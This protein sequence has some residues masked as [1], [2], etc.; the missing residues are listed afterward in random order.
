[1]G[2][3]GGDTPA[4]QLGDRGGH[5]DLLGVDL[6]RHVVF[7]V[8]DA[9]AS[10][11]GGRGLGGVA[12]SLGGVHRGHGGKGEVAR[13]G[14]IGRG[15]LELHPRRVL[16]RDSRVREDLSAPRSLC[17]GNLREHRVA[18][19]FCLFPLLLE[20]LALLFSLLLLLLELLALLL[21]LLLLLLSLFLLV[22]SLL[23]LLLSL[24]LLLLLSLF[25][26]LRIPLGVFSLPV[27]LL[28]VLLPGV[29]AVRKAGRP[30]RRRGR[31]HTPFVVVGVPIGLLA[32][33][34]VARAPEIVLQLHRPAHRYPCAVTALARPG[35][36]Q[37]PAVLQRAGSLVAVAPEQERRL[38]PRVVVVDL[39][40]LRDAPRIIRGHCSGVPAARVEVRGCRPRGFVPAVE[41]PA[42][43]HDAHDAGM[44]GVVRFVEAHGV[45]VV[46]V[47]DG[48]APALVHEEFGSNGAA[49]AR[50]EERLLASLDVHAAW[51][52]TRVGGSVLAR[53]RGPGVGR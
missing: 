43:E 52:V 11:R 9:A 24:L 46:V 49:G 10:A 17:V 26:L 37:P 4:L 14:G 48:V 36:V 21:S 41:G 13:G 20:L 22:L 25:L 7:G 2:G 19:G 29:V 8:E 35:L 32:V 15:L 47:G 44:T 34:V 1:M 3:G 27:L 38:G 16:A 39:G 6:D 45:H 53:V 18:L 50:L 51:A 30:R 23:L 28:L 40:A 12:K 5:V 31:D 42:V 33:R